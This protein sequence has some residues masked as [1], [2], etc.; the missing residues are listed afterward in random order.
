MGC[1]ASSSKFNTDD[2]RDGAKKAYSAEISSSSVAKKS[3]LMRQPT[4]GSQTKF[5]FN[6]RTD[7]SIRNIARY[8]HEL[9]PTLLWV[10]HKPSE[11]NM[12]T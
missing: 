2:H 8:Y 5:R 10:D 7:H 3:Q 4:E 12:V 6:L 9:S 1:G 11:E